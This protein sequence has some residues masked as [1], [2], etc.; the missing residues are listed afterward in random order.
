M[1]EIDL[2]LARDDTLYPIEVKRVATPRPEW[3]RHFAVLDRFPERRGPGAVVC[4]APRAT[5][6]DRSCVAVPVTAVG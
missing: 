4:L 5:A 2:L 1:K 3:C 6:L